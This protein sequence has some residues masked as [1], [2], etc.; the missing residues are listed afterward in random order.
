MRM[1][2]K[3]RMRMRMKD[4]DEDED[5]GR[6]RWDTMRYTSHSAVRINIHNPHATTT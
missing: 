5:E 6:M 1:R 2:M 3:T 4:E